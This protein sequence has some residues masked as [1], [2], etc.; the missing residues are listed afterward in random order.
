MVFYNNGCLCGGGLSIE[1]LFVYAIATPARES[2]PDPAS[3]KRSPRTEYV[4]ILQYS[5]FGDIKKSNLSRG[6][7]SL[8]I[9]TSVERRYRAYSPIVG[10]STH[11]AP[12]Y[13]YESSY[14]PSNKY[15][16][17][18]VTNR[19]TYPLHHSLLSLYPSPSVEV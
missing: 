12:V 9:F 5:I 2:K 1:D 6:T 17:S 8:M 10:C 16:A 11:L 15:F 18:S 13:H 19:N 14:L 7:V 3:K 4:R